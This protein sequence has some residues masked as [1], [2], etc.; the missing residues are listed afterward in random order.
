MQAI[1]STNKNVA[2]LGIPTQTSTY[3]GSY[4]SRDGFTLQYYPN[5]YNAI[6]AIDGSSATVARTNN[7]AKWELTFKEAVYLQQVNLLLQNTEHTQMDKAFMTIQSPTTPI[8]VIQLTNQTNQNYSLIEG[9]EPNP[10]FYTLTCNTGYDPQDGFCTSYPTYIYPKHWIPCNFYNDANNGQYSSQCVTDF[11]SGWSQYIGGAAYDTTCSAAKK[12]KGLCVYEN[13][14]P[15]TP[16]TLHNSPVFIMRQNNENKYLKGADS[17]NLF[18]VPDTNVVIDEGTN[19]ALQL[20]FVNGYLRAVQSGLYLVAIANPC[21]GT[22]IQIALREIQFANEANRVTF[23][24]NSVNNSIKIL[25]DCPTSIYWVVNSQNLVQTSNSSA[26][27]W[28]IS[29]V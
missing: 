2:R 8:L 5:T 18:P 19:N 1:D 6:N 4:T 7:N 17:N 9:K 11:G 27:E 14:Y 29:L 22:N 21:S 16:P 26:S 15:L 24:S 13:K 20:Q 3:G 12:Y 28:I 25:L 23:L 10:E